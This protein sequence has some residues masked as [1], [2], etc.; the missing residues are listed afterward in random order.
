MVQTGKRVSHL[1]AGVLPAFTSNSIRG[2]KNG[3]HV[4]TEVH[5]M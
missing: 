3:L 1:A 4:S 5:M 2:S